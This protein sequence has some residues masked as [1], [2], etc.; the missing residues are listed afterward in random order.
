MEFLGTAALVFAL[1][2]VVGLYD[3]GKT[4]LMGIAFVHWLVLGGMIY[5]GA[6]VSGAHYNTAVTVQ[7]M[8]L[9]EMD[10]VDGVIYLVM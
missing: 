1:C 9:G 4:S 7:F 8:V 2:H 5:V 10:L 6:H 3:L